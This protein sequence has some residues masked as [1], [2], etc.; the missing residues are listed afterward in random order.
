MNQASSFCVSF[1]QGRLLSET[2]IGGDSR[3]VWG[4]WGF[5]VILGFRR[6]GILGVRFR[7]FCSRFG[8][9]DFGVK[10]ALE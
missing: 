4:F 3:R 5:V 2:P 10:G 6:F 7:V 1:Q 9:L 8:I